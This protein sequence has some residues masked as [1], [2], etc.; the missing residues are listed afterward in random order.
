MSEKA[1][2]QHPFRILLVEDND[3]DVWLTKRA[4]RSLSVLTEIHV[5][6]DG[7]DALRFL[8]REPPYTGAPLPDLIMLD[9][10][11]P[12]MDG[13]QLLAEL[14]HD[15]N[16]KIIPAI[17]LS[18]SDAD[19]DV[20]D[21]YRAHASA[22]LTKPMSFDEFARRTKCLVEFWFGDVAILPTSCN[23]QRLQRHLV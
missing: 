14:K 23:S 15:D 2:S 11:M 8:R 7:V 18:T 17:V 6:S 16:L 22:Y 4:F 9:L 1:A 5:T 12:G 13:R 10:N 19:H 20:R 21:A 3:D